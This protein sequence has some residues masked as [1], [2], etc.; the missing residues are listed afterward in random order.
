MKKH[1]FITS[2]VAL[3]VG[4]ASCGD[5]IK[6]LLSEEEDVIS[7]DFHTGY[8]VDMS[9]P[10]EEEDRSYTLTAKLSDVSLYDK[11]SMKVGFHIYLADEAY[12][13][14]TSRG[15]YWVEGWRKDDT[16]NY[17]WVDEI[18]EDGTF[19][20]RFFPKNTQYICSA[21]VLEVLGGDERFT[22][23]IQSEQFLLRGNLQM[24][25][26]ITDTLSNRFELT[27][28]SYQSSVGGIKESGFCWSAEGVPLINDNRTAY[29][30]YKLDFEDYDEVYVR[31]YVL[32][33]DGTVAYTDV[34]EYRPKDIVY[35]IN[36]QEDIYFLKGGTDEDDGRD[37]GSFKGTLVF[38]T[39]MAFEDR[40]A[41]SHPINCTVEG[42]G[43]L[44][45]ISSVGPYGQ[46]KN[47]KLGY[48]YKWEIQNWGE[49]LNCEIDG[50]NH[51]FNEE[52]GVIRQS[53]G[54]IQEN[55]GTIED[56]QNIMI[57]TNQ[58]LVRNCKNPYSTQYDI[59]VLT[60]TQF[61]VIENCIQENDEY[62]ICGTN[63]G[64]I[65]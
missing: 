5:L 45:Y 41:F 23:M 21:C 40:M 1:L 18:A 47:A 60:N 61:G 6:E 7:M 29:H 52:G 10:E 8:S 35:Y 9:E 24:S 63:E 14:S 39:D 22:Q 55:M 16:T 58:G 12:G 44:L 51:V 38:N 56:C 3:A 19:S 11:E 48:S 50:S 65:R 36:D 33:A 46:V 64:I 34:L 49:I 54:W 32:Y 2:L 25:I 30:S 53:S 20:Y 31:G 15:P 62:R 27:I 13:E 57:S 59:M 28:N 26:A 37:I 17:K 4:L 42:N 43:H